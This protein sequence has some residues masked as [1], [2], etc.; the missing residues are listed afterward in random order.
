MEKTILI[1]GCSS[2]IGLEAATTL[3]NR[4]YTV[5]ATARKQTDIERLEHIGV[6]A[7]CLDVSNSH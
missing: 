1:T 7:L 5:F 6:N 2:G 3:H 4:G